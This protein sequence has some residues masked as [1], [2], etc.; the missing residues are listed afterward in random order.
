[1]KSPAGCRLPD[2]DALERIRDVSLRLNTTG[3]NVEAPKTMRRERTITI[4]LLS[5]I[6]LL[7]ITGIS[8]YDR[9]TWLMEVAPIFV[10]VPVLVFTHRRFPLTTFL[11]TLIALHA[12][13]LICGGAYTYARVP[14]GFWLQDILSLSRNPYDRI[15][16]FMQ[17]LVP[18]LV[19][20]EILIRGGY[21]TNRRMTAFLCLCVAMAISAWYEL[22]EWGAASVLG[23]GADELR[24]LGHA[25]GHV[26]VFYWC[27]DSLIGVCASP[28]STYGETGAGDR[29]VE[30]GTGGRVERGIHPDNILK[31]LIR[32]GVTPIRF[33]KI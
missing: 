24:P 16:H 10:A 22:I 5:T 25:V 7:A 4:L 19:A 31:N 33:W 1:M 6:G 3:G 11:Y 27:P 30:S 26:H 20:R 32:S 14:L 9:S 28:R 13:V 29:S 17:G 2:A 8:P 23:Q 12:V 18:T 15:G 21:L